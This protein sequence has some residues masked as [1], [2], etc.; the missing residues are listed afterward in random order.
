VIEDQFHPGTLSGQAQAAAR[1]VVFCSGVEE[2][3]LPKFLFAV[4]ILTFS[5]ALRIVLY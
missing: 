3:T 1:F 4:G 2:P 5:F